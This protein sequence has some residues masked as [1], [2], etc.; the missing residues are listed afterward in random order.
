MEAFRGCTNLTSINIPN[1][2]TNI[3]QWAFTYCKNLKNITIPDSVTEIGKYAFGF[4]KVYT[5]QTDYVIERVDGF[6]ISCRAGSLAEAYAKKN[7]IP[8]NYIN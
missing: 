6:T 7:N 2:V 3:G 4:N 5:G 1:S 8:I